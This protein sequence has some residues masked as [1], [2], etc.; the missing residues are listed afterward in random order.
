[1]AS[2]V[3]RMVI[4][5]EE[6]REIF[7]DSDNDDDSFSDL[8]FSVNNIET[9]ESESCSEN[10]SSEDEADDEAGENDPSSSWTQQVTAVNVD[11]FIAE[12]GKVFDLP[13]NA[14]QIDI[15][16]VLFD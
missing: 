16:N 14:K 11:D 15:F 1:M 7:G 6:F 9:S 13:T 8:E 10:E 3:E 2:N 5:E 4:T 12:T